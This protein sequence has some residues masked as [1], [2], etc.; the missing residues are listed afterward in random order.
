MNNYHFNNSAWRVLLDQ[1]DLTPRA[2]RDAVINR[3]YVLL[4][5]G[6]VFRIGGKRLDLNDDDNVGD[7]NDETS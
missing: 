4:P 6:D 3:D 1:P 7:P 5:N 2:D